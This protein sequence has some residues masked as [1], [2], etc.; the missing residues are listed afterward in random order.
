MTLQ[1]TPNSNRRPVYRGVRCQLDIM[2][3][4]NSIVAASEN[5]PNPSLGMDN[6]LA[7]A[8]MYV[9]IYVCI[10]DCMKVCM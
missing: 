3:D 5:G 8:C 6:I 7:G 4:A 2:I 10:Y 9:C 1:L